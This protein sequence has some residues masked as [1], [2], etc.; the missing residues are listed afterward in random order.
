M[1]RTEF[2]VKN[3]PGGPEKE[4]NYK[5]KINSKPGNRGRVLF[6]ET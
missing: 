1:P 5:N 2:L 4:G 3:K 6:Q